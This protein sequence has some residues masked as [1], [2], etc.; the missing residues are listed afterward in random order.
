MKQKKM[1]SAFR[2]ILCL[3]GCC[4]FAASVCT[5]AEPAS[6][7]RQDLSIDR[8]YEGFKEPPPEARPF[9]RW[10]WNNDQVEK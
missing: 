6:V 1:G 10:W 4:L 3:G 9:V 8:I 2:R 5:G 7:D